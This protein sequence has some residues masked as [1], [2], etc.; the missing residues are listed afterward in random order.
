MA[1]VY[2]YSEIR[3][4]DDDNNVVVYEPGDKLEG[5]SKE[6]VAHLLEIGAASTYDVTKTQG[7]Q[8]QEAME[9]NDELR[10]KIADLE[11]QL[12][13]KTAAQSSPP[14]EDAEAAA[15]LRA[16]AEKSSAPTTKASSSSGSNK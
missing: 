5:M 3:E 12:A 9:E 10:A 11:A 15:K 2:A 7:E 14:P 1:T 16:Q 4:L 8:A 13:A 6:R